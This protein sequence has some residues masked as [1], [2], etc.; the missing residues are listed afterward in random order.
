MN[1]HGTLNEVR[2]IGRLGREPEL[3]ITSGGS[4]FVT[5][6]VCTQLSW[7]DDRGEHEQMEW[8]RV[9]AWGALGETCRH[10]HTGAR[11]E[12]AGSIHYHRWEHEGVKQQRTEIKAKRILFLD[13]PGGLVRVEPE[14]NPD[15]PTPAVAILVK[16]RR[17]VAA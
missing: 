12:V 3:R 9:I 6:S 15:L 16:P 5:L 8:H 4:T 7:H 11:I 1:T 17:K 13:R 10:I 14:P 2:L